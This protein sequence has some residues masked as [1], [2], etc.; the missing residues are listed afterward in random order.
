MIDDWNLL[1]MSNGQQIHFQRLIPIN[2][3]SYSMLIK[4]SEQ[5]GKWN[6]MIPNQSKKDFNV[7][8]VMLEYILD[9]FDRWILKIIEGIGI[10][11]PI[12]KPFK[13]L[14]KKR[15]IIFGRHRFGWRFMDGFHRWHEFDI[16]HQKRMK[17]KGKRFKLGRKWNSA[18]HIMIDVIHQFSKW[19]KVKI[20]DPLYALPN[21]DRLL[22]SY[23]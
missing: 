18:V 7:Y 21:M 12:V 6:L 8:I 1:V 13:E 22:K 23:D 15:S 19:S 17:K 11:D 14:F 3:A 16:S 2:L 9:P 5:T 4:K 10:D 20:E